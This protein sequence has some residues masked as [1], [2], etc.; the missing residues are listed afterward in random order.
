M[1]VNLPVVTQPITYPSAPAPT[2]PVAASGPNLPGADPLSIGAVTF[3]SL[4]CPDGIS[5][6]AGE[7]QVVV[8]KIP[9]GSRSVQNFGPQMDPISWSGTIWQPNVDSRT[10][11]LLAMMVGGQEQLITWRSQ[12][13]Y[14]YVAKFKPTFRNKNRCNYDITI[15]LT[16]DGNG[17]YSSTAPPSL[18]SQVSAY[19]ANAQTAYTSVVSLD[20]T[21]ASYI[22][23]NVLTSLSSA[24]SSGTPL[25]QNVGTSIG[26]QILGFANQAISGVNQYIGTLAS[27][28]P[29]LV[30]A[31]QLLNALTLIG[32]NVQQGQ[33]PTTIST[34]NTSAYELALSN[35]GTIDDAFG[36][37]SANNLISMRPP[38]TVLQTLTIPPFP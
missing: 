3:T 10:E 17:A 8:V 25:A 23:P 6:S 4:E 1:A 2:P 21:A 20:T 27:F 15:E 38:S 22:N 26:A 35:G 34:I 7:A 13:Y 19:L 36:I 16:R 33:S 32:R 30:P 37:A 5:F 29:S 24:I 18:D 12:R 11:A 14:G 9:G 28:A 31:N